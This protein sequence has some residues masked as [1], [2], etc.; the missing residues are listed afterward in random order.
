[1]ATKV[2]LS[3]LG[4]VLLFNSGCSLF[5]SATQPLVIAASDPNADIFVDGVLVGRGT[6]TIQVSRN[7]G[8]AIM[9][10]IGDRVGTATTQTK[11]STTGILDIIGGFLFLLPFLGLLGAG[12]YEQDRESIMIAIPPPAS[13]PVVPTKDK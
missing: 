5:V 9:A 12:F 1:M 8:H 6:A 13:A 3:G 2:L 11:I 4:F 10:R 7:Q